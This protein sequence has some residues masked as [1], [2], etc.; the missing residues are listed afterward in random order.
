M[1]KYTL[2]LALLSLVSMSSIAFEKKDKK[3]K[4]EKAAIEKADRKERQEAERKEKAEMKERE[5][6][7]KKE[8]K[9]KK[10]APMEGI[11]M[12]T[13]P[14]KTKKIKATADLQ[15]TYWRLVEMNG[16]P[17]VSTKEPYIKLVDKKSALEG[18]TGC[19][20]IMGNY[21]IGKH[22]ALK[23]E[24]GTT[25]M[26]CGD[27]ETE[28]FVNSALVRTTTYDINSNHLLLY[29]DNVLLAVFEAQYAD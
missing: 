1:K 20:T 4:K 27:M 25:K 12:V 24:Y 23:F 11:T 18:S 29:N 17:V 6:A 3:E 26:M 13:K 19:N 16:K 28:Q 15:N 22:G 10:D 7:Q 5:H 8:N 2:I 21:K 14:E 9:Q